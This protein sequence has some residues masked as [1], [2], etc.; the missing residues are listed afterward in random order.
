MDITAWIKVCIFL[1]VL[2]LTWYMFEIMVWGIFIFI[3]TF[4][5]LAA[6]AAG[7]DSVLPSKIGTRLFVWFLNKNLLIEILGISLGL[8]AG[9]TGTI[10]GINYAITTGIIAT[11]FRWANSAFRKI[12][13]MSFVDILY[14]PSL[15]L[16]WKPGESLINSLGITWTKKKTETSI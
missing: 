16:G 12:D 9:G 11:M 15:P 1:C 5:I 13:G 3:A 10:T 2:A 6:A 7:T 14:R 4:S 8:I